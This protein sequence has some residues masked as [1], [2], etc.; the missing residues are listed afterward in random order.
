MALLVS[1]LACTAAQFSN[2]TR[3]LDPRTTADAHRASDRIRRVG[4]RLHDVAPVKRK[5]ARARSVAEVGKKGWEISQRRRCPHPPCDVPGRGSSCAARW[6]RGST[7][8]FRCG[9]VLPRN[10]ITV[11][12]TVNRSS[13]IFF[14][15]AGG[16]VV[17]F[18][19]AMP[20]TRCDTTGD[21]VHHARTAFAKPHKKRHQCID[22]LSSHVFRRCARRHFRRGEKR[23]TH[24]TA[25]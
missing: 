22:A 13:Q 6:C 16:Y 12:S 25:T 23:I 18:G 17:G 15:P 8:S 20:R 9:R 14:G 21:L 7:H 24:P 11:F 1:G 5:P 10:L 4:R 19:A 2:G 3:E